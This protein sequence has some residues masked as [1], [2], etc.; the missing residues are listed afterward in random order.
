MDQP[1]SISP[2]LCQN[3]TLDLHSFWLAMREHAESLADS[4]KSLTPLLKE[5]VLD[6]SSFANSVAMRLSRKLAREDMPRDQIFATLSEVLS[7]HPR[8]LD[9]VCLLYTSP[10]PRDA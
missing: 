2:T 4:E 10:S 9:S 3:L 6:R 8:I 7:L 5:V 1:S